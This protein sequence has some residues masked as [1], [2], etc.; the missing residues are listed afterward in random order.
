[1][2][3][4]NCARVPKGEGAE[5]GFMPRAQARQCSHVHNVHFTLMKNIVYIRRFSSRRSG[6][7]SSEEEDEDDTSR[8]FKSPTQMFSFVAKKVR[9]CLLYLSSSFKIIFVIFILKGFMFIFKLRL[10]LFYIN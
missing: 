4:S 8:N 9:S 10:Y 1:M 2:L 7:R 5:R 6:T 3:N